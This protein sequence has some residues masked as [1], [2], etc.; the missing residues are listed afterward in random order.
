LVLLVTG[1]CV[2]QARRWPALL[3]GWLIVILFVLPVSGLAQAG[4]QA[5]ADRFA[6]LPLLVILLLAAAGLKRAWQALGWPGRA[7]IAALLL[8]DVSFLAV[9]SQSQIPW[10][11]DNVSLWVPVIERYPMSPYANMKLAR[12]LGMDRRFEEALPF[13]VAS[14]RLDS[15]QPIAHATLGLIL[16]KLHEPARALP[17]LQ[18]ALRLKPDLAATRYNLACAQAR[19][20]N[21]AEA[22]AEL[23]AAS[24]ADPEYA[25]MAARDPELAALRN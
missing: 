15:S 2:W 9:R 20:G 6:Y 23:Q 12:A 25:A 10:W 19:L 14:V 4:A 1:L 22:R 18:A 13:A 3:A 21:L 8:C 5:V 17:E 11:H 7:A 16:L 24:A